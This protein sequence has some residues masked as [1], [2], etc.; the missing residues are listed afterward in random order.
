MSCLVIWFTAKQTVCS[1]A[2]F[3]LH[4]DVWS[5]VWFLWIIKG[6]SYRRRLLWEVNMLHWPH[7][8][9]LSALC[10]LKRVWCVRGASGPDAGTFS[11][12][13]AWF[14]APRLFVCFTYFKN[15]PEFAS[16]SLLHWCC[17]EISVILRLQRKKKAPHNKMCFIP[18][19]WPQQYLSAFLHTKYENL[20]LNCSNEFIWRRHRSCVWSHK[21]LSCQSDYLVWRQT[22]TWLLTCP[23]TGE[24]KWNCVNKEALHWVRSSGCHLCLLRVS[25]C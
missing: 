25:L 23:S 4:T 13:L 10:Q 21:E 17:Q 15:S 24:K 9:G 1:F 12:H 6:K 20:N 3:T 18:L 16:N 2:H 14:N 19:P 5:L 11:T 22:E 8:E 7:S